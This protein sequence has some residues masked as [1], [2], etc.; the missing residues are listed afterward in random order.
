MADADHMR[1]AIDL[2]RE[3]LRDDRGG[4]FGAV[5]V[6]EGIVVG[7]GRNLVLE[8]RDPTAHAE[9]EAI[10]DA[11]RRLGSP[12]LAGGTIYA[13]TEP[14]PMC[15]GAILWARLDALVYGAGRADAAAIGFD[16]DAF[17]EEVARPPGTRRLITR[18]LL[19]DEGRALLAA[20]A[21]R[22]DRRLY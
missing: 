17:H 14:C 20:W 15:L 2:A 10:R 18:T 3:A 1:A 4:P 8:R 11:C 7:R 6:R 22:P 16:D 5:V 12:S 21:A 9:I 19:G 13:S